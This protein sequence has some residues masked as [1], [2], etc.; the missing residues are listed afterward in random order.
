MEEEEYIQDLVGMGETLKGGGV[1][2]SFSGE[3]RPELVWYRKDIE[4]KNWRGIN[5]IRNISAFRMV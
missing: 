2:C 4:S 3:A 5:G 1:L